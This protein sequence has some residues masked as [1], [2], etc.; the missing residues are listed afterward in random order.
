MFLGHLYIVQ[1]LD[2]LL[3]IVCLDYLILSLF[4]LVC[5]EM[6]AGPAGCLYHCMLLCCLQL[7]IKIQM[8]ALWLI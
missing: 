8:I 7:C 3:D 5:L 4:V 2:A 6:L 1:L